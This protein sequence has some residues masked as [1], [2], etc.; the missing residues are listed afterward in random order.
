MNNEELNIQEQSQ[1]VQHERTFT[2]DEVNAIVQDRLTRARAKYADYDE[3]K[4]KATQS[5]ERANALQAQIDQMTEQAATKAVEEM[6][7]RVSSSTGVPV[8]LLT[9]DTEE[10]C[11]A[12]AQEILKCSRPSYP[13]VSD[14]GTSNLYRALSERY[15]ERDDSFNREKK[16]KPKQWLQL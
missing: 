14:G 15:I 5:E 8:N 4:S 10:A 9:F 16:H 1:N 7:Q 11:N 2:Q 12:Q 6:K 13:V 3:V